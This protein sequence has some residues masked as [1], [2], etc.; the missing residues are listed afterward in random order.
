MKKAHPFSNVA[1]PQIWDFSCL[2]KNEDTNSEI[3][4][5]SQG[6]FYLTA[7]FTYLTPRYRGNTINKLNI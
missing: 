6:D 4:F 7:W 5:T 1:S 3:F 2:K